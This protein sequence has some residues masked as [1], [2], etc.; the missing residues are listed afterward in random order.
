MLIY[1]SVLHIYLR[2]NNNVLIIIDAIIIRFKFFIALF[3]FAPRLGLLLH[4][5]PAAVRPGVL[6]GEAVAFAGRAFRALR[7]GPASFP[8]AIRAL[9][10]RAGLPG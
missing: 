8:P 2:R 3:T 5:L 10:C 4:S 9:A 6:P 7:S 1:S